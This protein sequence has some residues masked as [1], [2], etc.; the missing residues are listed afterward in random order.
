[1]SRTNIDLDDR[2]VKEGLKFTNFKTKKALVNYALKELVKKKNAKNI[3]KLM[4]SHCW[5]GNLDE[6]RRSRF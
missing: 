1:M 2:L 5:N 6:M 3:L 4:G